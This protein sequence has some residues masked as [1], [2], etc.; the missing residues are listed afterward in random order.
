MKLKKR[1]RGCRCH[2]VAQAVTLR[3]PI[4]AP[5]QQTRGARLAE[6]LGG[7]LPLGAQAVGRAALRGASLCLGA[8]ARRGKVAD[9]KSMRKRNSAKNMRE[10]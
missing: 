10:K 7:A 8:G 3:E 5:P 9:V 1:L 4:T 2:V 6:E